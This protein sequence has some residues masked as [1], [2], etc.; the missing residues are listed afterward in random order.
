M[1]ISKMSRG[2]LASLVHKVF[3]E[4]VVWERK[5]SFCFVHLDSPK[6][7]VRRKRVD[8]FTPTGFFDPECP[9]CRPFIEQGAL[10][11]YTGSDLVGMRLLGDGRFET[12]MLREN[13]PAM[14]LAN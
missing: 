8:E 4:E 10:M 5:G 3:G 6:A 11:V 13:N 1:E 7:Q 2:K 9:H 12:V 14:A